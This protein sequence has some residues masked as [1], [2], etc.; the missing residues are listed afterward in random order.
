MK[1]NQ[2]VEYGTL[3]EYRMKGSAQVQTQEF[4][5]I[6]HSTRAID[7]FVNSNLREVTNYHKFIVVERSVA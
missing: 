4:W 3:L 5:G 6:D 2:E 1:V 7:L